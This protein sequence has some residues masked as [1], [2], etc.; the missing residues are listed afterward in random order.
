MADR[1]VGSLR[2][3]AMVQLGSTEVAVVYTRCEVTVVVINNKQKEL[4][5]G[6]VAYVSENEQWYEQMMR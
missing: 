4:G 1:V 6:R 3:T 5:L 2:L